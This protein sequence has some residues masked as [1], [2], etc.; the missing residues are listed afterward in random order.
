MV[1]PGAGL[2]QLDLDFGIR[3]TLFDSIFTAVPVSETPELDSHTPRQAGS[4]RAYR[5]D[6]DM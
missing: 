5:S 6:E 3:D 2:T 4:V 1:Q